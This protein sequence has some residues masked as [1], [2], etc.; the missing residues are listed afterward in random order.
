MKKSEQPSLLL[1][2]TIVAVLAIAWGYA[3]LFA[4]RET[5]LPITFV[6]PMLVCVWTRRR[7]QLWATVGIF[8][9]MAV[10][11]VE[12]LP[13]GAMTPAETWWYLAATLF[14]VSAGAVAIL[15]ILMLRDR[16]DDRNARLAA[17]NAELEAQAEELAQQNEEIKVQTEELAQQNEEIGAQAEE[18]TGQNEEL[19]AVN[20]RLGVREEI[21]QI[22]LESTRLPDSGL[23]ALAN[24]CR[25]SL[26]AIGKPA[27]CVAILRRDA[28]VFR[29]KVQAASIEGLA[30]PEEWP[31][32]GT[33]GALA[34]R[35]DKTGYVSDLAE[36]PEVAAPFGT[37]SR[38]R[39]VLATPMRVSGEPYG[40]V[41]ACS[42]WAGH[43]TQE[44]F[45]VIEWIA[46]QCGLIAEGIR[47]RRE[48]TRRAKEIEA[49]NATKDQF[50]AMLSHE[51]RTPL[52]PVLAAAGALEGDERLPA[53]VRADLGMIRRNVAIQSRLVDDLL[54][55]TRLGRGKVD[56]DLQHFELATLL[57]ETVRIVEPDLA[58]KEQAIDL[59]LDGL[60]GARVHGDGPR[61][62]RCFG[63]C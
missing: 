54:D 32:D 51:L 14:N 46:A 20:D 59:R 16:L 29:V 10:I 37:D 1:S 49:A 5:L 36:Q 31:L 13:A 55:L 60:G 63:I 26:H 17:Q 44:Q 6:V 61:C 41:L 23:A 24:V 45:H 34:L 58:A 18:L 33:M 7:W 62:S 21:L 2:T 8:A 19:Q 53:D 38:I 40:V 35:Q 30:V 28:D 25:R 50:L 22:L 9:A 57:R 4:F 56:L 15:L 52:T 48:L 11:K 47:W 12:N 42:T 43:W 27:E 3:R 39:S